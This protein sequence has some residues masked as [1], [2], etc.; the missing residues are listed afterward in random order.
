[1]TISAADGLKQSNIEYKIF[2]IG[3]KHL[4]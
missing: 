3:I 4:F 1:V 2:N